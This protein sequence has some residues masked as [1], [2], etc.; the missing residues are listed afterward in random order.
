MKFLENYKE[1]PDV[2]CLYDLRDVLFDKEWAQTATDFDV[3][4]MYRGVNEK[5]GLRYDITIIPFRMFGNEFPKTKGHYHPKEYGEVYTVLQG[6]AIYLMQKEDLSDVYAVHAKEGG[7]VV[8]PPHYGHITINPGEEELIMANWVSPDFSSNYT[9]ILEK[10]GGCYFFTEEGWIKNK[11]YG[12]IPELRF[13]EP[14][15]GVPEDLSF[16]KR[17]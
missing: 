9:P 3:Y 8:I 4:Y 15:K 6:E 17:G 10:K 5:D 16:L 12:E 2:R 11:T 13:E 7:A 14:I 1:K